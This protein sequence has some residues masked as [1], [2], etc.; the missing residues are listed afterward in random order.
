MEAYN[1][2]PID[3]DGKPLP[4]ERVFEAWVQ[5]AYTLSVTLPDGQSKELCEAVYAAVTA[6]GSEAP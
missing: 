6:E 3:H 4:P 5:M 2:M 1:I